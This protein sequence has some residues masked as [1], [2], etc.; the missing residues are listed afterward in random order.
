MTIRLRE[1]VAG[2]DG[3]VDVDVLVMIGR[4][5]TEVKKVKGR[6]E[7]SQME[8]CCAVWCCK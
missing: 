2:V 5:W 4:F 6:A 7:E 1:A 3:D 8:L